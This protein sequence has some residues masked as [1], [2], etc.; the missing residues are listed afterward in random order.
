MSST[1]EAPPACSVSSGM[2]FV[3]N[4]QG[5]GPFTF[6]I[7]LT[8]ASPVENF[9]FTVDTGR[10]ETHWQKCSKV[11]G[12]PEEDDTVAVDLVLAKIRD[13]G[14]HYR[15]VYKTKV[16][17]SMEKDSP[18]E[19]IAALSHK[20]IKSTNV[21]AT[22]QLYQRVALIRWCLKEYPT[23][24]D[25]D[26]WPK[27]DET[28][29][30]FRKDSNNQD[31]LNLC[32]NTI[33]EDDK[34]AHGDPAKTD[35][36]TVESEGVPGWQATLHKHARNVQPMPKAAGGPPQ[37]KRRVEQLENSSDGE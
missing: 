15:N 20:L 17:E 28:I 32:F 29:A 22:V 37:K 33:Y 30:K 12:L 24:E 23:V 21:K 25:D 16:K 36:K 18:F 3:I 8:G 5:P 4:T 26:F 34:E 35:F 7:N 14:T 10:T 27:V 31:E 11:K 1:P 2:T 13:K 19:N 9:T 6:N